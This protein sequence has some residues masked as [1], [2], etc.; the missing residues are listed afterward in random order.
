MS[1]LLKSKFAAPHIRVEDVII[2][3]DFESAVTVIEEA[4]KNNK[5]LRLAYLSYYRQGAKVSLYDVCSLDCNNIEYFRLICHLRKMSGWSDQRLY[6]LE[7]VA[8]SMK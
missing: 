2:S 4:I 6:E 7:L 8:K 1:G 5:W 3:D